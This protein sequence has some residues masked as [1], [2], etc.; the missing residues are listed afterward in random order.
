MDKYL[1]ELCTLIAE[2]D[3]SKKAEK[4]L[5]DIL[6][7]SELRDVSKRLQIVKRLYKGETQRKI[8]KDLGVSLCKV[9]RGSHEIKYGHGGF[10]LLKNWWQENYSRS[11]C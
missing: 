10:K 2:T 8:A 9:T 5:E 3:S 6:T 4:L 11:R 1:K 7:E